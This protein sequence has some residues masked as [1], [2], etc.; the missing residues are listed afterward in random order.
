MQSAQI[1]FSVEKKNVKLVSFRVL[2]W[3]HLS[4]RVKLYG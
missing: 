3:K 4:R 1:V 2:L